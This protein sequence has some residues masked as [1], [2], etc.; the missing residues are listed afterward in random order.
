MLDSPLERPVMFPFDDVI[1]LQII[2]EVQWQ[3]HEG[4]FITDTSTVYL[5]ENYSS[6]INVQISQGPMV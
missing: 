2:S 3:S 1:M 6:E 5:F 4:I